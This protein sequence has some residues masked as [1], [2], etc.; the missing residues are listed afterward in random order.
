MKKILLIVSLF[1]CFKSFGQWSNYPVNQNLG[2]SVSTLV[3]T[4]SIKANQGI[5]LGAFADTTVANALPYLSNYIG[6]M[7]WSNGDSSLYVR[8]KG[9]TSAFWF[10][11]GGASAGPTGRSWTVGGNL[12]PITTPTRDIGTLAPY[13]GALGL[14]TNG[15]VWAIVPDAG[16][17]DIGTDTTSNKLMAWNP[18]TK[19]W[20]WA[21]WNRGSGGSGSTSISDLTAAIGPN[22]IDNANYGQV[23]RWNSATTGQPFT[24]SSNSLSSGQLFNLISTSTAI[25]NGSLLNVSS[26]GAN[27]S[28]N[29]SVNGILVN[30]T[31]TGTSSS[32][33]GVSSIAADATTNYGLSSEANGGTTSIGGYFSATG[34]SSNYAAKFVMGKT[35]FGTAG[36]E[37]G[38]LEINGSTSGTVTI[39]PAAAAGTYTLTLPTTD[40]NSGEFLQTDGSGVLTWGAGGS[41]TAQKDTVYIAIFGQSNSGG[42]TGPTNWDTTQ[43]SNVM[44]W[45][46]AVASPA[47]KTAVINERPF[48]TAGYNSYAS[49]SP[50]SRSDLNGS[51]NT[52]FYLGKFLATQGKAA[53]IV[54]A[55]GDGLSITYWYNG[56]VYGQ[57]MDSIKTRIT[58]SGVPRIDLVIWDQGEGDGGMAEATYLRYLDTIKNNLIYTGYISPNTPWVNCGLLTA[59]KGGTA[60]QKDTTLRKV[61]YDRDPWTGYASSDSLT[62]WSGGE[63]VHFSASSLDSLADRVYWTWQSLPS[64]VHELNNNR[65]Q[66]LMKCGEGN[67]PA[68]GDSVYYDATL[69]RKFLNVYVNGNLRQIDSLDGYTRYQGVL[70]FHPPLATNDIVE[71]HSWDST[72]WNFTAASALPDSLDITFSPASELQNS[73][74]IWSPTTANGWNTHLG[75]AT[76]YIPASTGARVV[77]KHLSG[78]G[79]FVI[80]FTTDNG[81]TSGYSGTPYGVHL[82]GGTNDVYSSVSGSFTYQSTV[83]VNDYLSIGRVGNQIKIQKSSDR[84]SWT[85]IYTFGTTTNQLLYIKLDQYSN[86]IS[87]PQIIF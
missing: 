5:I 38:I 39:Q 74:K 67:A 18:T 80:G 40:G 63:N 77:M 7:I 30:V 10:K 2:N 14:M 57:M 66:L 70:T 16:F 78:D 50:N 53:K 19:N 84:I 12:F 85:D 46:H 76:Q 56:S 47:W 62:Q 25:N 44:V 9:A 31:N 72:Q 33:Y 29:R 41:G 43:N 81:N 49:G 8:Y 21:N 42:A 64:R 79:G 3:N 24:I 17:A 4:N 86:S 73:S 1:F 83:S 22:D 13:G 59:A 34:A 71:I 11:I 20:G 27:S 65:N 36:T 48:R 68:N 58:A 54:M 51:S 87:Y 37:S 23:W 15:I 26:S 55:P 28:S 35:S 82:S 75:V 32:N 6:A 45:N 52:A 69:A 61:D 60:W